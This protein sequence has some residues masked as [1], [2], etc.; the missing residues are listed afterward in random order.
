MCIRD[1][2]N[3]VP[4]MEVMDGGPSGTGERVAPVFAADSALVKL[5][6]QIALSS[7]SLPITAELSEDVDGSLVIPE[8]AQVTLD[9]GGHTITNTE[10]EHTI[11]NYGC[12]LYTST[13]KCT[14][15]VNVSSFPRKRSPPE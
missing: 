4:M 2:T 14:R 7:E 12:L 6:D 5:R 15:I 1:R 3:A 8:Y 11:T 10:N 13:V 9:L